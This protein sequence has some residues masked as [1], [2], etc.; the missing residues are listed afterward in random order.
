MERTIQNHSVKGA[1]SVY[2]SPY[3]LPTFGISVTQNPGTAKGELKTWRG[4]RC[5]VCECRAPLLK[6]GIMKESINNLRHCCNFVSTKVHQDRPP[7]DRAEHEQ[8]TG[9]N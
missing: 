1:N 5:T 8:E 2:S 3:L 4:F 6:I 7:S 9:R